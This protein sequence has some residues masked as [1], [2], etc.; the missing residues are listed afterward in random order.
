V[1]DHILV[2]CGA[3]NPLGLVI[4][5]NTIAHLMGPYRVPHLEAV[6]TGVV[7]NKV[8]TAL[9]RGAGRTEAVFAMERGLELA[10]RALDADPLELRLRN[11]VRP[12]EMPLAAGILYRDGEPLVLDGGDYPGAL[13]R[14]AELVD[15]AGVRAAAS[16]ACAADAAAADAAAVDMRPRPIGVG[17]ASY[18]E[19]TGV[20]PLEGAAVA[21]GIDGRVTIQTGAC[22]QGQGHATVL[23]QIRADHLGVAPVQVTVVG[24]DTAGIER[25]WGTVASRSAVVAGSAVATAA[26]AVRERALEVS[27]DLLETA[28]PDLRVE[29]GRVVIAG[30]PERGLDLGKVAT[31]AAAPGGALP[32]PSTS[33]RHRSPGPTAPTPRWWRSIRTPARCACSATGWC[34]T[35]AGSSTR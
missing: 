20:G 21:V 31:A 30:A 6:A 3:F 1:R 22:S 33:S 5:Y 29:A 27:A 13:R 25:G 16:Q 23:A 14:A 17:L 11:L 9:Y 26:A 12:D 19:G 2:D 24:G 35:A 18:I 7:T 32:P 8:P 28:P 10:A 34:T 15:Y 4:A